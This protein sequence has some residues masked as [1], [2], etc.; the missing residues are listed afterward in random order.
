MR[1]TWGMRG[2][3]CAAWLAAGCG[4]GAGKGPAKPVAPSD[5]VGVVEKDPSGLELVLLDAGE[6]PRRLVR[7]TSAAGTE[8]QGIY[9]SDQTTTTSLMGQTTRNDSPR[10]QV[11]FDLRVTGVADNGDVHYEAIMSFDIVPGTGD[12]QQ[13]EGMKEI[14]SALTG[15]RVVASVSDRGFNRETRMD[16]PERTPPLVR[17]LMES[18]SSSMRHMSAPVPAYPV[19]RGA[20]WEFRQDVEMMGL[21]F[22]QTTRYHVTELTSKGF[23]AS[24]TVEQTAPPQTFTSPALPQLQMKLLSMRGTGQGVTHVLEGVPFPTQSTVDSHV[25][26]EMEFPF[27]PEG[28]SLAQSE[29]EQHMELRLLSGPMSR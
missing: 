6:E 9:I 3:L 11:T 15:T 17:T 5:G 1:I 4:Q 21:R 24:V 7:F 23:T 25:E 16:L 22:S 13:A 20:R 28:T 14:Y 26:M 19:G 12:H 2:A 8:V 18:M 27:G 10:S 29:T